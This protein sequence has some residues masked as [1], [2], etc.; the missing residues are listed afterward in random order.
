MPSNL[1]RKPQTDGEHPF[2]LLRGGKA[3]RHAQLAKP[4]V[5][6]LALATLFRMWTALGGS[7]G[8]VAEDTYTMLRQGRN[9]L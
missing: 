3:E 6:L 2:R 1:Q 7:Q 4:I 8:M 5:V 9:L